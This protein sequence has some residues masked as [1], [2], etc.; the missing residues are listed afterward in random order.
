M[1]AYRWN[2]ELVAMGH[3]SDTAFAS[4]PHG[5]DEV[6]LCTLYRLSRWYSQKKHT[7]HINRLPQMPYLGALCREWLMKPAVNGF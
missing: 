5:M 7:Q 3:G 4:I 1:T 2:S 6:R